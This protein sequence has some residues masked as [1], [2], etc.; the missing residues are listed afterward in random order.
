MSN[1]R[2]FFL[3]YKMHAEVKD[4]EGKSSSSSGAGES[5]DKLRTLYLR[6]SHFSSQPLP[7]ECGILMIRILGPINTPTYSPYLN[8]SLSWVEYAKNK[9][10][11]GIGME[12]CVDSGQI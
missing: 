8:S 9:I 11:F 7:V 2:P 10:N 4:S 3:L 5:E 12:K 1:L 6:Q